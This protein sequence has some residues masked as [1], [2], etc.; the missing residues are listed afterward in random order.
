MNT[1]S[2]TV[3]IAVAALCGATAAAAPL[4]SAFTYQ[5]RLSD[6]GQPANGN[7]DILFSLMDASTN[8]SPVGP[9]LP[10]PNVPVHDGYFTVE[11]DFGTNAFNGN[12]RWLDIGVR[13]NCNC[14]ANYTLL[15]PR[16]P[17]N[18]A[19]YAQFSVNAAQATTAT[20][21]TTA[22]TATT[23]NAVAWANITGMP[24]GFADGVDNDTTYAAGSGLT[25]SGPNNQFSVNFGGT[26]IANTAARSDHN[27]FGAVW[28]GN[29]SLGLG[30][31]VTNAANNSV[32]L[33]GQQGTGSGFP[34]IFGN[35]AGVW[36]ESS[37][38]SGVWGASGAATGAGVRGIAM[39]SSGYGLYGYTLS[40][41]GN[42]T[43]VYGESKSSNGN[44]VY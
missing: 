10:I 12:S 21:A 11:L 24:A 25:L 29:V 14:L 43:G 7:Y 36:G 18:A 2:I 34:Y 31:S 38:G 20:S 8:G 16:Q 42:T 37:Q 22:N 27:H 9:T 19:P 41:N 13:T 23:A 3:S 39:G 6:G 28:G 32:G 26:G 30:L 4:G 15:S 5:G 1:K 40:T 17:L 44:G 33:F 35:T